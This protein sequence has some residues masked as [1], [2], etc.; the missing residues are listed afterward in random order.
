MSPFLPS[1]HLTPTLT[2]RVTMFPSSPPKTSTE[3]VGQLAD[4]D[5]DD[6]EEL[7]GDDDSD[8]DK[9]LRKERWDHSQLVWKDHVE[10]LIHEDAFKREYRMSIGAWENLTRILTPHV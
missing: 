4:D 9:L 7:F 1:L 6:L 5:S 10:K 3:W 2:W 8:D